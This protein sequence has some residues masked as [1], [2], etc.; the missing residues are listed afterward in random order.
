MGYP[1]DATG[2]VIP[3][4]AKVLQMPTGGIT[5]ATTTK[6]TMEMHLDS[7]SA[8]TLPSSGAPIDFA[9]P[10]T[11]NNATSQTGVRPPRARTWR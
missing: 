1:A 9:D 2:T 10:T 8:V 11:Y 6:V 7:R 4:T 3:G 5:P